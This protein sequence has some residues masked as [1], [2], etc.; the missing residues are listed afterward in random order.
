M[1]CESKIP[2]YLDR[3]CKEI[4]WQEWSYKFQNC[5]YKIVNQ[6]NIDKY[7]ISTVWTGIN[8][9]SFLI[10]ETMI[11][12]NEEDKND[13]LYMYQSKYCTEEQALIGHQEAV[14]ICKIQIRLLES[15]QQFQ[16]EGN[17]KDSQS[18]NL[19]QLT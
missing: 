17:A 7:L 5:R 1:Y 4:N 19:D 12:L 16:V 11:F 9:G 2:L 8:T 6:E 3:E 10:F 15:R 14:E 13:P 18:A